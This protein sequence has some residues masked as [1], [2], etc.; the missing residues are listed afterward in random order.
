MAN[1]V[2]ILTLAPNE[3]TNAWTAFKQK[4]ASYTDLGGPINY[5]WRFASDDSQIPGM[6]AQL[7]ALGLDVIVADGTYALQNLYD[8]ANPTRKLVLSVGNVIN[9][10]FMANNTVTGHYIDAMTMCHNQLKWFMTNHPRTRKIT[11]LVN[12]PVTNPV[13]AD[14]MTY[15]NNNYPGVTINPLSASTRAILYTKT[16]DDVTGGFMVIPHGMFY[17]EA[18]F[19]GGTLVEPS[20]VPNVF[21]EREYKLAFHDRYKAWVLGH[22][23]P[24]TFRKAA[25]HVHRF[26]KN[27]GMQMPTEADG[28]EDHSFLQF[29]DPLRRRLAGR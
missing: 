1:D 26:L 12:D 29:L 25:A 6:A 22:A 11:V 3:N 24:P 8:A 15:K 5:T 23:I 9:P 2:G 27:L 4:L 19:I 14:L 17:N 20:N 16:S 13:Y 10:A 28:D 21:P 7:K 18:N